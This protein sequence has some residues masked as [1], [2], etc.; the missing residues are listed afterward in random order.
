MS[1]PLT[2]EQQWKCAQSAMSWHGWGSPV[3]LSIFL[4]SLALATLAI[5]LIIVGW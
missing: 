5:R 3:G 4:V 2:P 1:Q